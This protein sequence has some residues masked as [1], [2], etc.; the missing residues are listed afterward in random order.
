M[1]FG[2]DST[3]VQ[4]FVPLRGPEVVSVLLSGVQ[5]GPLLKSSTGLLFLGREFSVVPVT[6]GPPVESQIGNL[7]LQ[8][9]CH[10]S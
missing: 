4:R 3:P 9:F 5:G 1:F 6:P 10:V 2:P 7:Y 8:R